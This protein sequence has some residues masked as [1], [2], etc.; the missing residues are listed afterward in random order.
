MKPCLRSCHLL[1]HLQVVLAMCYYRMKIRVKESQAH[2]RRTGT[3]HSIVIIGV[4]WLFLK[5]DSINTKGTNKMKPCL[6]S[7]HLLAHLQVVLAMCYYRMK[8]RVKESQAHA[9]RT[10]TFHS[11]VTIGVPW[12]F[13]K[14][15][16]INTKG[17][18]KM[19]PCLLSCHLLAHLQVVL[20]MCYYRMKI[21]VKE[22]QAHARR[23]GTFHSIVTIGVPWLFLKYDS[24]NTKGTNKMKPCLRSCH[25][26]AHLQVVLAMCYYRMKIRVK[27][28]QAHARRTGTF[29]SIVTIGVFIL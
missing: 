29:H 5:Y 19:K 2:A 20:A 1:A 26:L 14:Y 9:R 11:I 4:P 23:T 13:L 12:L 25:L 28:S 16:S 21:R 22:S 6:R 7:C 3:F 8:I 24:I 17:T 10:G 18:N 27:E 15:D